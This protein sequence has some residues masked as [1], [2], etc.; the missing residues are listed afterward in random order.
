MLLLHLVNRLLAGL[1]A[2]AL[3]ALAVVTGVE[4]VRWALGSEPWVVPWRDW[5]AT[6]ADLRA[7]DTG[8]LVVSAG[9]LVVGLLLLAFELWRRR[10]DDLDTQPL[11][12]G[13]PTVATRSGVASAATSA[14][15]GV[16]GVIGASA[17]VRRQR[18]RVEVRTRLRGESGPLSEQVRAAVVQSLS[19]L[20]VVRRPRITVAVKEAG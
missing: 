9:A 20:E 3:V 19:D 6:L 7:D 5:G 14:A 16:S 1:V 18:L 8:L 17:G 4:V 12:E 11:L 15:R 13:V 2:L 10:P